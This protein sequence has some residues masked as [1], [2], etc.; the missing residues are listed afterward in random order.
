MDS[1]SVVAF[2]D[3]NFNRLLSE[4]VNSE[5]NLAIW[6]EGRVAVCRDSKT[7]DSR[8]QNMRCRGFCY[9]DTGRLSPRDDRSF[10][11]GCLGIDFS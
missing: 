8:E 3:W 5:K 10:E 9:A 6:T 4:R 2:K 7:R 11:S 1:A